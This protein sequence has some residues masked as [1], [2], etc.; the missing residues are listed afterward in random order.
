MVINEK[1]YAFGI[2]DPSNMQEMCHMMDLVNGLALHGFSYSQWIEQLRSVWEVMG[3]IHIPS[4]NYI[5]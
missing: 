1:M 5:L 2:A 4:F 3:S